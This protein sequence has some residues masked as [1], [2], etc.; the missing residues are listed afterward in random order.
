MLN[1][2]TAD[3]GIYFSPEN[4]PDSII[5]AHVMVLEV[6]NPSRHPGLTSSIR[7]RMWI[8]HSGLTESGLCGY[9]IYRYKDLPSLNFQKQLYYIQYHDKTISLSMSTYL[10]STYTELTQELGQLK[11]S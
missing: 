2:L 9:Q 4:F 7:M 8:N 6:H 5:R 10:H 11:P 3:T 1:R